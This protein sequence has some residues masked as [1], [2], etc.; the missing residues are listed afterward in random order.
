M[1]PLKNL[2][3]QRMHLAW[4]VDVLRELRFF[5]P[6]GPSCSGPTWSLLALIGLSLF[7]VGLCLGSCCTLLVVS[8]GLRR[9]LLVVASASLASVVPTP[10]ATVQSEHLQLRRRLSQY[11]EDRA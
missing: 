1:K 9:G 4:A 11:R 5:W 10:G 6:P 3:S 2:G 7:L 8:P